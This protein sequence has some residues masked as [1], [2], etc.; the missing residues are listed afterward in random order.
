[1]SL[2]ELI[3]KVLRRKSIELIVLLI[4]ALLIVLFYNLLYENNEVVY[5][6]M[7][8]GFVIL[9]YFII[10]TIRYRGFLEK[11]KES[12]VSPDYNN[13]DVNSNEKEILYTISDIHQ[14]Y[15]KE[16][17][18][19][20]QSINDKDNL[21]SQWIHNMKTSI[22]VISLACEK[23]TPYTKDNKYIDDIKEENNI[24]KK[25][26]EEAL[27]VLRL[28]DFSRDY[29]TSSCNLRELVNDVVNNKKRDFIYKGVF[30]KVDIHERTYVY[31]D[32]K[33]CGYMLDQIISNAIKYSK[34]AKANKIEI[35]EKNN[36]DTIEL[37]IKDEGVGITK[38]DLSRVF[39]PFFT[40]VNGRKERSATGIGLYMVRSIAKKLEHSVEIESEIGVG[41]QVKI[42]FNKQDIY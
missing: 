39:D 16:I 35:Y 18:T 4:N 25:N 36:I 33:W 27:N 37:F 26:L 6:L 3:I 17:H 11:L 19:L 1:M 5:P 40:G 2:M 22:T 30:P 7:L 29:I 38:E 14:N 20:K 9:T 12:I 13:V 8:S 31:T 10:A 42:I 23:S 41:T 24:L 15:L 28:E 34:N 21:F 32:K